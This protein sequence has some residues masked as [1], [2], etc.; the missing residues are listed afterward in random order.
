M[1]AYRDQ[2]PAM[3]NFKIAG[4]ARPIGKRD[5]AIVILDPRTWTGKL[6][7]KLESPAERV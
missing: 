5:T 3:S 6:Y 7:L 2:Y 1:V 4:H